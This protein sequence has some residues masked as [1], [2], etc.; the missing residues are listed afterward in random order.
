MG[1]VLRLLVAEFVGRDEVSVIV[2]IVNQLAIQQTLQGEFA[3]WR[4]R[5]ISIRGTA[6]SHA[7]KSGEIKV[8]FCGTSDMSGDGLAKA[9]TP[10]ILQ[11]MK[12]LWHLGAV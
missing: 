8:E 7:L 11:R 6:I 5:H 4:T 2:K 9:L 3:P 12:A 10:H 1:R